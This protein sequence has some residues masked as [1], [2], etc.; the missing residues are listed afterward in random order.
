M[1]LGRYGADDPG[2]KKVPLHITVD[3]SISEA[4]GKI[5]SKKSVSD[6]VNG[7]LDTVVRQFDPGPLAPMIHDLVRIL[8]RHR[9]KAETSGDRERVAL[10]DMM[11][12][13]LDPYIDLAEAREMLQALLP[14][15]A[16]EV[17]RK[18][19]GLQSLGSRNAEAYHFAMPPAPERPRRDYN[20]YAVPIICHEKPMAYLRNLK[21]WKCFVCG[22]LLHDT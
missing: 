19:E 22:K 13:K 3:K 10:I 8:A 1:S 5:R 17:V 14:N 4:L 6:L 7:L 2:D 12:S 9:I 21:A 11:L 20:W 18:A 15:L 16:P